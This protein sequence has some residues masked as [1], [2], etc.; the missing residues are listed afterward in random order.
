[1]IDIRLESRMSRSFFVSYLHVIIGGQ[2]AYVGTMND[3]TS[4]DDLNEMDREALS[5]IAKQLTGVRTE[6][7]EVEKNMTLVCD[8]IPSLVFVRE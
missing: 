7:V 1:M 3:Q 6:I 2:R 5:S 4:L 8:G